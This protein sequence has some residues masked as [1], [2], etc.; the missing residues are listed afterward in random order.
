MENA[1]C[2]AVDI[3]IPRII[4]TVH[5]KNEYNYTLVLSFS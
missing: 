5:A 2:N 4:M 3:M 1:I